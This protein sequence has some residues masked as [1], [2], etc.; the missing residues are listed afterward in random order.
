MK[1]I[2]INPRKETGEKYKIISEMEKALE[3]TKA[4]KTQL[5]IC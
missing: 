4:E 3:E 1:T 5:K 2:F